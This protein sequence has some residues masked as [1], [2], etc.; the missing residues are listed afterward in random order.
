[1]ITKRL[2]LSFFLLTVLSGIIPPSATAQDNLPALVAKIQPSVVTI[3]TY[4]K[5]GK[6][7]ATGSGFF[8]T[9]TGQIVTN[10]HVIRGAYRIKAKTND[11]SIIPAKQIDNRD[12]EGD[13]ALITFDTGIATIAPLQ[14]SDV[15]PQVGERVIVVGSPLGFLTQTVSDGIVSAVRNIPGFGN[16][17]QITAPIS[18]GSSGSPVVNMKG[19]VIGVASAQ[20]IEGQNLNFAVASQK[21]IAL[22]PRMTAT[23]PAKLN[24]EDDVQRVRR[25]VRSVEQY[26]E[27]HDKQKIVLADLSDGTD[28]DSKPEWKQ[29]ADLE[30]MQ[31]EDNGRNINGMACVWRSDEGNI[32]YVVFTIQ[33]PSRD[34]VLYEEYFFNNE[35]STVAIKRD[36]RTIP[37]K[38][39]AVR[40]K[41]FSD[42]G[43]SLQETEKFFNLKSGSPMKRLPE[44]SRIYEVKSHDYGSIYELPFW[45]IL[46]KDDDSYTKGFQ[47][48]LAG[49]Y[50]KALPFL[51]EATRQNKD[52]AD[53]WFEMGFCL[54]E[55][56]RFQEGE[57]AYQRVVKINAQYPN[58][59]CNLGVASVALEKPL[60]AIGHF[61]KSIKFEPQNATAN[62]NLGAIYNNLGWYMESIEPLK[63][64]I[65]IDP[66]FSAAYNELGL[67]YFRLGR[68]Q[69][70]A[71]EYKQAIALDPQR[72]LQYDN[73]G[74][75]C[76]K[77]GRYQD[78]VE[79]YKQAI[80]LDPEMA[81]AQYNLGVAYSKL[82]RHPD[83]VEAFKQ[84]IR[85][86]PDYALAHYALGTA[87]LDLGRKEDALEA[88]KEAI[89]LKP[90]NA[91]VHIGMGWVYGSLDRFEEALKAFREAVKLKPDDAWAHLGLGMTYVLMKDKSSAL[92]EYKILKNLDPKLANDL[93]N[94]IYK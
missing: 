79:A 94:E 56:Q 36:F 10:N 86:K 73:L 85:L 30:D 91:E 81:N 66:Q 25:Y 57:E 20:S 17:L 64:A 27:A 18:H 35:G 24:E 87:Y 14:V 13:L 78:A 26:V 59:E 44:S 51:K 45:D 69:D 7:L 48:V 82:N 33:S 1:M 60:E 43:A 8:V 11:G 41:V 71:S 58:A 84:A 34:W 65:Q 93:F 40:E 2:L 61:Q 15:L 9:A 52:N 49:E 42:S 63:R 62:Y 74:M 19:E 3:I 72:A 90:D 88:Y 53:A 47:F 50:E 12:K 80:R 22:L 54:G 38:F 28:E 83:A 55:L 46:S 16:I 21:V 37:G 32:N 92:D 77:L 29:F 31:K 6:E 70:A 76:D 68:F 75:A 4:G 67:V 89:R 5:D 23:P 39:K